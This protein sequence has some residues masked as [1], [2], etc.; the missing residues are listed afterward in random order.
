M[1]YISRFFIS[2]FLFTLILAGIIF[3]LIDGR[4]DLM[5]HSYIVLVVT[6]MF[7]TLHF[8][9][10]KKNMRKAFPNYDGSLDL[11][12]YSSIELNASQTKKDI[13]ELKPFGK[14]EKLNLKESA[15]V[16]EIQMINNRNLVKILDSVFVNK[17]DHTYKLYVELTGSVLTDQR[18]LMALTGVRDQLHS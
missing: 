3:Y 18:R 17:F 7:T 5:S 8:R 16:Y 12:K 10:L 9:E 13:E 14:Y 4:F 6:T 15:G 1:K 11:H 2:Y